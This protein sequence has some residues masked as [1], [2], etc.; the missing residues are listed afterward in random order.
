MRPARL[1]V[2][3]GIVLFAGTAAHAAPADLA[4]GAA[5]AAHC[6]GC[7]GAAGISP[8]DI[9][10]NLA[11]QKKTYLANQMRAFRSGARKNSIMESFAHDLTDQDITN[12]AAYY[13][14][15]PAGGVQGKPK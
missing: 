10:P 1:L 14:K 9:W 7:H 15:L 3:A 2:A 6:S 12:L 11:G 4:A 8:N 5:K 13:A